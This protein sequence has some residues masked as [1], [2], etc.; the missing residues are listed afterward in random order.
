MAESKRYLWIDPI[1]LS[2]TA[3]MSCLSVAMSLLDGTGDKQHWC[4]RTWARFIIWISK[5]EVRLEGLEHVPRDRPC[6][7][8]SNHQS[9]FDIWTLLAS[10][11]IQFRFAAKDDL[12]RAPFLGWHLRRSGNIP[13]HRGEPVKALRSIRDAARKITAGVS[14]LVFPEGE[15]SP[16][17]Q[18]QPFKNGLF[19]LGVYSRAPIVPIVITGSRFLLPKGSM[20]IQPGTIRMRVL[21]PIETDGLTIKGLD[22]LSE[23]VR[24]RMLAAMAE[25]PA[26]P[27]GEVAR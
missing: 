11:P 3:F 1:I 7:L 21:P 5:A 9:F 2:F 22:G 12:F 26:S 25:L 16:D 27:G 20:R 17:G 15:R 4:A 19:M 10:L 24:S 23:Q 8:A 18:L 14:V 6:L 13:I